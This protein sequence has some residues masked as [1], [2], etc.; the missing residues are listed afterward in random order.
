[1]FGTIRLSSSCTP[2]QVQLGAEVYIARI[3][4]PDSHLGCTG[5]STESTVADLYSR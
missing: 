1:M 2:S 4:A 5:D 3:S